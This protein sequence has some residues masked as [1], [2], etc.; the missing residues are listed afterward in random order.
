MDFIEK[1]SSA[2]LLHLHDPQCITKKDALRNTRST[3]QLKQREMEDSWLRARADE[4]Q[5]YAD[6]ND[7]NNFY[8]SLKEVYGLPRAGSSPL[9]SADGTK[10]IS[11]NKLLESRAEH[12]DC[13]LNRPSSINDNAIER[14]PQVSVNESPHAWGKFR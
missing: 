11:E 8:S 13:V 4:I 14:L 10:L 7:L 6:K 9:L 1:R 12:F 3:V 5:S 2:H